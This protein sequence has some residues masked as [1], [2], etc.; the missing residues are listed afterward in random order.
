[1][2]RVNTKGGRLSDGDLRASFKKGQQAAQGHE[3]RWMNPY[4][5]MRGRAWTYGWNLFHVQAVGGECDGCK[6]CITGTAVVAS[7]AEWIRDYA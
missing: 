5:S 2:G 1:M 3:K 4:K 6:Q 7:F